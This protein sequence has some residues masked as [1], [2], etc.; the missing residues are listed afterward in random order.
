MKLVQKIDTGIAKVEQGMVIIILTSMIA[1]ACMQIILR[2]FFAT[3]LPW[4][5]I[6]L[7]H[8]VLWIGFLGASLATREGKHINIDS[9]TR[10]L[11]ERFQRI[12]KS[13]VNC[14]AAVVCFFLAHA[15]FKFIQYEMESSSELFS[16]I[17]LWTAQI[18]IAIGFS[19]MCL[20]F[21]INAINALTQPAHAEEVKA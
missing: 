10:L 13:V 18:I 16:G 21:A 19:L 2:N 14:A 20:R 4:G 6:L 15:G 12:S 11:S 8:L 9:L 1:I 7:R 3:S 17:P 5:D